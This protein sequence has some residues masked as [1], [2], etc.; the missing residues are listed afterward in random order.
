V[1]LTR[2]NDDPKLL[3]DLERLAG[4]AESGAP[5]PAADAGGG[6]PS[7]LDDAFVRRFVQV[8][9]H[10]RRYAPFYA[11]AALWLLVILVIQPVGRGGAPGSAGASSSANFANASAPSS[12]ASEVAA[13]AAEEVVVPAAAV[14]GFGLSSFSPL[15]PAASVA[16]SSSSS[17][18]SPPPAATSEAAAS[19]RS[20]STTTAPV[21]GDGVVALVPLEIV[22]SGYSS[23]SGGTPAEQ[24]PPRN[25][26]PVAAFGGNDVRRSFVRLRGTETTLRLKAM[27]EQNATLNGDQAA[28]KA[29]GITTPNWTP[30]RGQKLDAG[31]AYDAGLC[32]TGT[33]GADG[34]W[35]FDL[36]YFGSVEAGYGFALVPAAGTLPSFQVTFEPVAFAG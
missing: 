7:P 27:P 18:S 13:G 26:L 24:S 4:V 2:S 16:E 15:A 31:P 35:T 14:D 23:A 22:A 20:P 21:G 33:A 5:E 17:A 9:A 30:A 10:V 3:G 36:T 19:E 1:Q 11:G 8:T 29:C 34:V 12:S 6:E 25:G 32:S 28:V